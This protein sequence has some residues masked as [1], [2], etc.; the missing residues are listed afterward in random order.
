MQ[1]LLLL[2]LVPAAL[3]HFHLLAPSPLGD[4]TT[5]EATAPCGGYKI[6]LSDPQD[7][8]VDGE[9][10]VVQSSHPQSN[11]LIRATFDDDADD[12]WVQIYPILQQSGLGTFCLP[13]VTFPSNYTGKTGIISVVGSGDDGMLYQVGSFRASL[14]EK[15]SD[16]V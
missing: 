7:V 4:D 3:A 14:E 5:K 8:H 12:D 11:W 6:D 9:P 1:H 13:D 16:F 2:A 15:A 10:F